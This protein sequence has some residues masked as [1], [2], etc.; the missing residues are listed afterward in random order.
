[1]AGVKKGGLQAK[2]NVIGWR[3]VVSLPELGV[4]DMRAKIDTGARTSALHAEDQETFDKDGRTWV[5]FKVPASK[6]HSDFQV[7]VPVI[8]QRNI[9]NTS[10]VPERRIVIR[11]L[12]HIGT[13]HW[14]VDV[15]LANRENMGFDMILGRTAIR[16]HNVLVHAG[17]SFLTGKPQRAPEK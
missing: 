17:R 12:L 16:R 3:E 8:D 5:R 10:G 13:H 14:H 1:M 9:K 6:H 15:S 2:A 11:T 7:E 4:F